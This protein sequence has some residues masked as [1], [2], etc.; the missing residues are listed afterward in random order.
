MYSSSN[1]QHPEAP[2]QIN[3]TLFVSLV[4]SHSVACGS[5]CEELDLWTNAAVYFLC[6]TIPFV[7]RFLVTGAGSNPPPTRIPRLPRNTH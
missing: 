6:L 5:L 7:A 4:L 3:A 2:S 1:R